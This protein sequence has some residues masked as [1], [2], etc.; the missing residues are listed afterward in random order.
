MNSIIIREQN[1]Q[2]L[3]HAF[4]P[5]FRDQQSSRQADT[6]LVRR[7]GAAKREFGVPAHAEQ[8]N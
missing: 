8:G 6:P 2:W 5:S 3:G 1:L 4:R 7:F